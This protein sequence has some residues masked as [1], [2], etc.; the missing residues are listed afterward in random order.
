MLE[1][2]NAFLREYKWHRILIHKHKLI[3]IYFIFCSKPGQSRVI[4][5]YQVK[6]QYL[7]ELFSQ[8]PTLARRGQ[9]ST[10]IRIRPTLVDL[11]LVLLYTN[12]IFRS[13]QREGGCI[14]HG[15]FSSCSCGNP[16][17]SL[18]RENFV[19]KF[20]PR[21]FENVEMK[22]LFSPTALV[23]VIMILLILVHL[24]EENRLLV[25]FVANKTYI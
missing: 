3:T 5:I 9:I 17:L 20:S 23:V 2:T 16:L 1:R 15:G 4:C 19:R 6:I 21:R 7:P 12:F 22:Q 24:N 10:R 14:R 8:L 11:Y 25:S 18:W 13:F